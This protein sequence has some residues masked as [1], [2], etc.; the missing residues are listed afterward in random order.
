M[1]AFGW[2]DDYPWVLDFTGNM[3]AYPGTYP[4]ADGMNFARDHS[5]ESAAVNASAQQ[6][7]G[8]A[9]D[10][11]QMNALANKEVMY[12]WTFDN[13]NFVTMTSNVQGLYWNSSLGS[14][15]A[16]G[17]GPEYF[18]SPLLTAS[19][20]LSTPIIMTQE[21]WHDLK[22]YEYAIRRILLMGLVLFG[23]SLMMFYLTRGF[24][25]PQLRPRT[26]HHAEDGRVA[27]ARARPVA[28]RSHQVLPIVPGLLHP[29]D[30]V[31]R[32]RLCDQYTAWLANVLR[33]NW[34]LTLLPGI[35]GTQTTWS[36]F[37]EQVPIHRPARRDGGYPH[38]RDRHPAGD[39]LG[40]PQQQAARPHLSHDL[41]GGLLHP[42]VLVRL[43]AA[44][45]L[46]ALRA[47]R[48]ARLDAG[49]RPPRDDVRDMLP[50]PR[51][52][53]C[54]TGAPI[55]DGILA[56]NLRYA[57]DSFVAMILPAITLSITSIGALTRI[58]RSSM[59][60]VLKQDYIRWQSRRGSRTAW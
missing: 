13:V 27:E 6:S 38:H 24:L 40:H 18:A 20:V 33:G 14:A 2:I 11:N 42:P 46:R 39:S 53:P 54:H 10:S 47:R 30:G 50:R 7:Q 8:P 58:V 37:F 22:L 51:S 55:L 3:L 12:L 36:V 48:R 44:D 59:L 35:A 21:Q 43:C 49:Q 26:L 19:P 32:A 5:L 16:N 60:E 29:P 52:R 9:R 1:Y 25:P 34:G 4:G 41:A 23:L 45:H 57:W 17:V 56:G 15:A 31:H 28:R